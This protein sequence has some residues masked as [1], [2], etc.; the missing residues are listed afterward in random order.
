MLPNTVQKLPELIKKPVFGH[1]EVPHPATHLQ[2]HTPCPR[3][4]QKGQIL[5][6]IIKATK[7]ADY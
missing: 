3:D 1:K 2:T 5:P 4:T 7:K 6:H